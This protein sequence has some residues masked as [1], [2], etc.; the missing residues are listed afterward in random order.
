MGIQLR[1][2]RHQIADLKQ[3]VELGAEKLAEVQARLSELTSP[4]LNSQGLVN[5]VCL[6]VGEKYAEP[7]V[8][9]LLS[10]SGVMRQT[11]GPIDDV[12]HGAGAAIANM[13]GE[14]S[15]DPADWESVRTAP[16][17]AGGTQECPYRGN[18]T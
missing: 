8:R 15:I 13:G 1:P 16:E 6:V 7:L 11:G 4:T 18:R 10:L 17:G 9:Q 5:A 12:M 3:I 14:Y 2:A